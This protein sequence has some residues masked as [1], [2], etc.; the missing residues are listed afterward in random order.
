MGPGYKQD[1]NFF[2]TILDPFDLTSKINGKDKTSR[3]WEVDE[4]RTANSDSP[5]VHGDGVGGL[6]GTTETKNPRQVV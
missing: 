5:G 6:G 3:F 2:L 1:R 4:A